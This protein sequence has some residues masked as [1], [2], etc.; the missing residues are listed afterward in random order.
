MYVYIYV[1]VCMCI[2]VCI[3]MCVCIY[4]CVYIYVYIYIYIYICHNIIFKYKIY[5]DHTS[6]NAHPLIR[7]VI[8]IVDQEYKTELNLEELARRVNVTPEYLSSL[9]VK[10]LGVKFTTYYTQ[11]R[12]ESAKNML[13]S[14]N[15]KVYEV[16]HE[17]GYEDVKYFCKVFKKYVG[18]SPREYQQMSGE[19]RQ[20]KQNKSSAFR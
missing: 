12:I 3:Y 4:V 8:K 9:F 11:K 14:G 15:C 18:I 16:A 17:H 5:I 13:K 10:E 1:C 2:Y 6:Q 7:K 19:T 20:E